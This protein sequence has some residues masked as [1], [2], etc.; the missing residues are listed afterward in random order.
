MGTWGLGNDTRQ[1]R[2]AQAHLTTGQAGAQSEV[3]LLMLLEKFR[4]CHVCRGPC[5]ACAAEGAESIATAAATAAN[6]F[7]P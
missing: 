1:Q 4:L 7:M 2:A 5:R 6:Y 3:L